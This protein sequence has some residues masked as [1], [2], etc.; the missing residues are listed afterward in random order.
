[1]KKDYNI[2]LTNLIK[3]IIKIFKQEY[4]A[5]ITN[6]DI[7]LLDSSGKTTNGYKM[8]V[9]IILYIIRIRIHC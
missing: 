1:M 2:I 6:K 7:L 3:N 9:H 8:S 4:N 5:K